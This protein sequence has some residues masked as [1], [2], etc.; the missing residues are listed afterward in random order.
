MKT[1][2]FKKFTQADYDAIYQRLVSGEIKVLTDKDAKDVNQ[3]PLDTVKV[4]FIQ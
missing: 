2:R 1:S 3:L 4:N